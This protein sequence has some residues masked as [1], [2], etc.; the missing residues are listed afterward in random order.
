V[1]GNRPTGGHHVRRLTLGSGPLKRGSDRLEF[2]ARVLLVCCLVTAIP[3]ALAVGTA[4]HTKVQAMAD[5]QAAERH[6][7][8]ATLLEVD[9]AAP[10]E[11]SASASWVQGPAVWT[12]PA[13]N[14]R[15]GTVAVP[16]GARAGITVDVWIDRE[17]ARTP[18]P[19]SASD[20]TGRAFSEGSA[21]FGGL[22][23]IAVGAYL[24]VRR[25]LDRSRFRRWAAEWATVE[26]VWTR[27]VP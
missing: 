21:T 15:R 19:L 11:A 24:S 1:P 22:S 27:M 18:P 6:R 14:E 8:P 10:A 2:L 12:D 9:P 3:I 16:A 13:G 17:G 5:A 4:T 26:P 23:L 20:A 25:L 7:V